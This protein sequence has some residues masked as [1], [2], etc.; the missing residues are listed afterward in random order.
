MR[1]LATLAITL[2]PSLALAC[3]TEYPGDT[4]CDF[5]APDYSYIDS[6]KNWVPDSIEPLINAMGGNPTATEAVMDYASSI[7]LALNNIE[8]RISGAEDTI[9]LVHG[10]KHCLYI[11]AGHD[12]STLLKV[13]EAVSASISTPI[14]VDHL[15]RFVD[16]YDP[17]YADS[18]TYCHNFREYRRKKSKHL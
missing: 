18:F 5:P 1:L 3:T 4:R 9:H 16:K 15:L 11:A 14:P 12:H 2:L 13:K 10:A 8:R 7:Y 17:S 6:N